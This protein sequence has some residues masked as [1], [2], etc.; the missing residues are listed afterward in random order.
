MGSYD[1][2]KQEVCAW[3]REHFPRDSKILD[4][5]AGD[6]K[7]RYL[8]SDYYDMEAVEAYA[9]NADQIMGLY[10]CVYAADI[11]G[12]EYDYYDLIILGDVIEH[13]SVEH[14][15]AVLDYAAD[16][17]RD[18]IIAVPFLYRQD[19]IYDNPYEVH[20]QDDLTREIFAERY[21]GLEVL[22][23]AA[24]DYCYYHKKT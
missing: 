17:C 5:G 10:R 2:G 20:I 23:D 13:M 1:Y 18:M 14:A 16:H 22:L 6:G 4:V 9:P 15:Q 8:L 3:I 12:F 19:A 11:Y 24:D 7:W 21:K